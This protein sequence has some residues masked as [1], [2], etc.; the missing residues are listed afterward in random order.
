MQGV[1][2]IAG[3]IDADQL[4]VLGRRY[5]IGMELYLFASDTHPGVS[6]FTAVRDGS[7]LPPEFCPWRVVNARRNMFVDPASGGIGPAVQR[8]GYCLLTDKLTHL[9]RLTM[10]EAATQ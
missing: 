7:H 3:Q 5:P 9:A 1:S 8:D 10:A 6:A 2:I 4:G